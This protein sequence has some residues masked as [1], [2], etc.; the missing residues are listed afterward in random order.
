MISAPSFMIA[1]LV[2]WVCLLVVLAIVERR[3]RDLFRNR[4]GARYR[5]LTTASAL[6]RIGKTRSRP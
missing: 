4:T 3:Q 1:N 6:K 5:R 2:V